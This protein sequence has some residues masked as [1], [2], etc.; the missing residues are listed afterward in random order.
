[1]KHEL[2]TLISGSLQANLSRK[3]YLQMPIVNQRFEKIFQVLDEYLLRGHRP[4][5]ADCEDGVFRI[6]LFYDDVAA[7]VTDAQRE[8][9]KEAYKTGGKGRKSRES[10]VRI[11]CFRCMLSV[12][13][14]QCIS[15]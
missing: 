14:F 6:E 7:K 8:Q 9:T 15:T 3:L 12:V 5:P 10:D 13:C 2:T 11:Q 4:D 1:M